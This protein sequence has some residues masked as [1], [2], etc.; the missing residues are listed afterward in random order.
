[1]RNALARMRIEQKIEQQGMILRTR[2]IQYLREKP[3]DL[4]YHSL[5]QLPGRDLAV[6]SP[7]SLRFRDGYWEDTAITR[8]QASIDECISGGSGVY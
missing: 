7:N 8:Y 1:M 2:R 4:C 5:G 6:E 3:V